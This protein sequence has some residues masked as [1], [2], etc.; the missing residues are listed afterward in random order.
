M[1][2]SS[3][4]ADIELSILVKSREPAGDL[5][6]NVVLMYTSTAATKAGTL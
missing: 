2:V 1:I 5:E 6:L 3:D 4:F